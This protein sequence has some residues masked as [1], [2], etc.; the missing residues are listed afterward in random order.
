MRHNLGR[1]LGLEGR[2]YL[3]YKATDANRPRFRRGCSRCVGHLHGL[4]EERTE[5]TADSIRDAD[6][7]T[8]HAPTRRGIVRL[9]AYDRLG[10]LGLLPGRHFSPT[11][12]RNYDAAGP[13]QWRALYGPAI[14]GRVGVAALPGDATGDEPRSLQGVGVPRSRVPTTSHRQL[15]RQS[16]TLQQPSVVFCT[17]QRRTASAVGRVSNETSSSTQAAV[18]KRSLEVQ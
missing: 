17:L 10:G 14:H 2:F 4:L 12:P 18:A 13:C 3:C 7:K 16:G 1:R 8:T 5:K 11:G 6:A 9:F 15:G